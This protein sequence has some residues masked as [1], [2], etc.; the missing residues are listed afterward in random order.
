MKDVIGEWKRKQAPPYT[1]SQLSFSPFAARFLFLSTALVAH[2]VFL[3][4]DVV[5]CTCFISRY[6]LSPKCSHHVGVGAI[7]RCPRSR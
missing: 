2:I 1:A 5:S 4:L 3:S 6:Y 7:G